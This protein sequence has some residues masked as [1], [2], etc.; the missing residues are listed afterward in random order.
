[1]P[2]FR[3]LLAFLDP[4]RRQT[5]GSLAL[6]SLAMGMTVLIPWLVGR[7][8][9][10]I[11]H[12]DTGAFVPLALAIVA[13]GLIRLALT[14]ARRIV[15]GKVSLAV[16]YDLRERVYSHLQ[17]LELGYFDSQQTGQLMSR[18]TVDLQSIRFF[19]GY[20]LVFITQ[21]ALTL[22]LAGAVHPSW[23][24]NPSVPSPR[25]SGSPP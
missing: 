9:N 24:L 2:T 14:A 13:A 18:A 4:Y 23:P 3:R 17:A 6:A 1:M 21:A 22:V 20:G 15:A 5:I 12:G 10:A 25:P 11:D 19:L 16:E 8:I 7:T